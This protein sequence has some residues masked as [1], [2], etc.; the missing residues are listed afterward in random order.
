MSQVA[1]WGVCLQ[2]VREAWQGWCRRQ[3]GSPGEEG[4]AGAAVLLGGVK[5]R[6]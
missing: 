2:G 3:E 6:G 4:A 1:G 5:S